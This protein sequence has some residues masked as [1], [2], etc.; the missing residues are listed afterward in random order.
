MIRIGNKSKL[1]PIGG[2]YGTSNKLYYNIGV[3]IRMS[4]KNYVNGLLPDASWVIEA[5]ENN[6]E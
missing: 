4:I 1:N 5:Y 3:C 2:S 6:K